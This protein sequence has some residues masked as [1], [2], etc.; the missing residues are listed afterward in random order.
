MWRIIYSLVLTWKLTRKPR[1]S[2]LAFIEVNGIGG[3]IETKGRLT[4]AS[5]SRV[6]NISSIHQMEGS[7]YIQ[8][9]LGLDTGRSEHPS[10]S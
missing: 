8:K 7:K 1:A 4:E 3:Y 10:Q 2:V 6:I 9:K 5:F